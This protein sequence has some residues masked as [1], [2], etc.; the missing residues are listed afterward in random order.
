MSDDL[1]AAPF[2]LLASV[3]VAATPVLTANK[4]LHEQRDIVFGI[5]ELKDM[6]PARAYR[7]RCASLWHSYVPLLLGILCFLA[8]MTVFML[9]TARVA[10]LKPDQERYR[11]LCYL[12]T[13][14]PA[15]SFLGF[16][17]GGGRDIAFM[18]RILAEDFENLCEEDRV[19]VEK[20]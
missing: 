3:W 5:K 2:V 15:F 7:V 14:L 12:V 20:D 16:L 9:V 17:V 18:R 8:M 10:P 19:V 6:T 11:W 4:T 13:V 1:L